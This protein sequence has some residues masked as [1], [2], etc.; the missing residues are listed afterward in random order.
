M[1]DALEQDQMRHDVR[2]PYNAQ[3]VVFLLE[4]YRTFHAL[5]AQRIGSDTVADDLLQQ[6]V[7]KAL[8]HPARAC[9][10]TRRFAWFYHILRSTLVDDYRARAAEE[11]TRALGGRRDR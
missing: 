8:E 4:H 2:E 5:V 7:Q 10:A 6:S 11:N 3:V 1:V 9:E